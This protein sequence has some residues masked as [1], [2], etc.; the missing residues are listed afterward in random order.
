MSDFA[1]LARTARE[2]LAR[3]LNALQADP[4]VPPHIVALATPIA[5]AMGTLHQ[6]ER[7]GS[8][9]ILANAEAALTSVQTALAQLQLQPTEQPAVMTAIEAVAGALGSVHAL[10]RAAHG[11]VAPT[12]PVEPA[13]PK[14]QPTPAQPPA[15]IPAH[16]SA[17]QQ[18]PPVA[19]TVVQQQRPQAAAPQAAARANA[20][21]AGDAPVMAAELGAHSP[22][23]FFK[24]L[25]GNDI[26]D[27]GGLF[28]ATY[29]LPK[30]GTRVHLRV[31]LPGGY[32][33]EANAIVRWRREASDTGSDSPPGFGAQFT[34]ITPEARQLVYRYVRNRE[35]MFHD[36]L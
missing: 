30:L 23:N 8:A 22:S 11:H 25:A 31:S 20:A 26:V 35:P 36:D 28:V 34:N 6:I 4:N 18:P 9:P 7:S 32:E 13:P 10:I 33:F 1:T 21:P 5:Q 19:P 29:K 12:A 16:P 15:T 3:G 27:H 17:R 14:M 2:S 24:G